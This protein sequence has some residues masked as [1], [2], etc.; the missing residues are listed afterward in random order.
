MTP[1]VNRREFLRHSTSVAAAA[2]LLGRSEPRRGIAAERIKRAACIGVLPERI[3]VQQR[4][5]MAKA[6]GFEGIEPNTL[7]TPDEVRQYREASEKTGIRIH[8]IMN[9]DHWRYPL[10]D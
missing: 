6:A 8:S 10:T 1:T 2:T 3:T 5:E 9:A 4:F 7:Y